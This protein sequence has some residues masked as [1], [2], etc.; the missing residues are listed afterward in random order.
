MKT[1]LI[2]DDEIEI[3]ELLTIYFT[4]HG[5]GTVAA[6][7]GIEALAIMQERSIDLIIAYYDASDGWIGIAQEDKTKLTDSVPFY[8]RKV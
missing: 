6:G 4:N 1:I 2:I 5:Y 7:N 3:Q 8:F